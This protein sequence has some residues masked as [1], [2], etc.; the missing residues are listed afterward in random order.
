MLFIAS[1][2]F[3]SSMFILFTGD[4]NPFW[5]MPMLGTHKSEQATPRKPSDQF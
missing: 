4:L 1:S 5:I 2:F 3:C